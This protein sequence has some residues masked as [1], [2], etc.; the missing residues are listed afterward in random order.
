[1]FYQK[2]IVPKNFVT[3]PRKHFCG[4]FFLVTKQA[5]SLPANIKKDVKNLTTQ[6]YDENLQTTI[7]KKYL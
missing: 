3:L 2:K 7:A 6:G 5:I 4:S 1:M